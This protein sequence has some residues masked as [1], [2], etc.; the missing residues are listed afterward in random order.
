MRITAI[1]KCVNRIWKPT[2]A[3]VVGSI[4]FIQLA[5]VLLEN[6]SS[7]NIFGVASENVMQ[8]TF[9]V[10]LIGLPIVMVASYIFSKKDLRLAK[11]P[12]QGALTASGDYKQRIAVIPF[13]NLNKDHDGGFLVDGI[14]EDVITEFSMIREIEILSRQTCFNLREKNFSNEEYRNGG[15]IN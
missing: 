14:V 12:R 6:I 15:K 10:S 4:G 11:E 1:R 7:E 9:L 5:S 13:A 8:L 2:A 3:Y